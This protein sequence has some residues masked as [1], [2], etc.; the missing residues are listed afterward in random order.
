MQKF[1]LIAAGGA[2]GALLRYTISGFVHRFID[3]GFPWGTLSV[4][5]LGALVIGFLWGVFEEGSIPPNF[6]L[7]F[8]VG[9]LGS[10][11][12]FSTYSLESFNLFREGEFKLAL[13]NIFANNLLSLLGVLLG[14]TL[15]RLLLYFILRR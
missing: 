7:F 10:L 11:T 9:L 1:L 8:L 5:V 6:R 14:F 12:T 4:N 15:A 2:T 13:S 3:A